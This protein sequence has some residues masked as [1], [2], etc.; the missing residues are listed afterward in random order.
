MK[1]AMIGVY[2]FDTLCVR[3]CDTGAQ[4]VLDK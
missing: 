4:H 3:N 1:I 2:A